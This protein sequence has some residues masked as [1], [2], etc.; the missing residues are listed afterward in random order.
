VAKVKI[1][2][3]VGLGIAAGVLLAVPLL[4]LSMKIVRVRYKKCK[5]NRTGVYEDSE[6]DITSDLDAGSTVVDSQTLHGSVTTAATEQVL[7][8]DSLADSVYGGNRIVA[9]APRSDVTVVDS[10]LDE[11]DSILETTYSSIIE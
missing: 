10:E 5:G 6:S 7:D 8:A 11:F 3:D 4:F 9:D 1:T 2:V